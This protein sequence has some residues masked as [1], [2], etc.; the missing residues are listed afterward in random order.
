MA[1][2]TQH[3]FQAKDQEG[4]EQMEFDNEL[5]VEIDQSG[6]NHIKQVFKFWI[7]RPGE[8][9]PNWYFLAAEQFAYL[10]NISNETKMLGMWAEVIETNA[11]QFKLGMPVEV[12]QGFFVKIDKINE[13]QKVIL[14]VE[15]SQNL[16]P[17]NSN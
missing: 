9:E 3:S 13:D 1:S 8:G 11:S 14:F 6:C 12:D 2:V 17:S 16:Y 10:S 15:L 5:K 7:D 4:S